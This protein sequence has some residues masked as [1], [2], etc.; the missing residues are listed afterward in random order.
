[1]EKY[2]IRSA[3]YL[4]WLIVLFAVIL[5]LMQLTGT[6][7]AGAQESLEA[8]FGS[9]RGAT[10]LAMLVVLALL[11]PRF[12]FTSRTL[13]ITLPN[14][15]E[16]IMKTFTLSGFICVSQSPTEWVFQAATPLKK[17]LLLWE[18]TIVVS[19]TAQ[20]ITLTGIRKEVVKIEFRLRSMLS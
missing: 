3:K 20:G 7:R 9:S 4:L 19:A 5:L 6:A 14:H 12:G 2:L 10:M 11:Y 18:D 16:A 15:A 8:L 1:M 17:A 13:P